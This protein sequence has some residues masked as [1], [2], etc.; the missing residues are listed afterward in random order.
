MDVSNLFPD[1]NAAVGVQGAM[2]SPPDAAAPVE[3]LDQETA[4]D[5]QPVVIDDVPDIEAI[6]QEKIAAEQER[7]HLRAERERER[8][9]AERL[10]E[11]QQFELRNRLRQQEADNARKFAAELNNE[12]PALAGRFMQHRSFLEQ[13]RDEAQAQ[14]DIYAKMTDAVML[15]LKHE[16]P[17]LEQ[18]VLARAQTLMPYQ[19]PE[20]MDQFLSQQAS[21]QSAKDAEIRR[22]EQMVSELQ[23]QIGVHARSPLADRVETGGTGIPVTTSKTDPRQATSMEEWAAIVAANRR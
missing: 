14:A 18:K 6:L 3:M 12:D 4:P 22:L 13:E 8:Q 10:K 19:T 20:E 17:D 11:Q 15:V 1:M 23:T 2:S 21:Q 7:D 9:E 16:A 5:E